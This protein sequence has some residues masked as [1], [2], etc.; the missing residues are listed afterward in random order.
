MATTSIANE[1]E[2]PSAAQ[3]ARRLAPHTHTQT[4][5]ATMLT[6]AHLEL[7]QPKLAP[8]GSGR[9]WPAG[10]PKQNAAQDAQHRRLAT[11]A[12]FSA[13]VEAQAVCKQR[14]GHDGLSPTPAP[15][16]YAP[17]LQLHSPRSGAAILCPAWQDA[18]ARDKDRAPPMRQGAHGGPRCKR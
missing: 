18:Q 8:M 4:H 14:I 1:I 3:I 12:P 5:T 11:P 2:L 15:P 6:K 10:R 17:V 16:A 9:Q 13:T 7:T